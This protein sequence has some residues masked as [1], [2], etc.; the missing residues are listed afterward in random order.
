MPTINIPP[1]TGGKKGKKKPK[2]P[3]Q[4][5]AEAAATKAAKK[6]LYSP[7]DPWVTINAKGNLVPVHDPGK[8][9]HFAGQPLTRSQ[10]LS[11]FN[12]YNDL[13]LSY[14]GRPISPNEFQKFA[15]TLGWSRY[16]VIS[17]YLTKRPNFVKGPLYKQQSGDYIAAWHQVY[18]MNSTPDPNAIKNG[19]IHNMDQAT[20]MDTLMKRPDYVNSN[21]F[22][23]EQASLADAYSSIYGIPDAKGSAIIQKATLGGWTPEQLKSWLR[24]QPEYTHSEEFQSKSLAFANALMGVSGTLPVL[25]PGPNLASPYGTTQQKIPGTNAKPSSPTGSLEVQSPTTSSPIP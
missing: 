2:T 17:Q 23:T 22:K 12:Q 16:R 6:K 13:W 15:I 4:K 3:A 8:A 9:F 14:L 24:K 20:F 18:G 11:M 10:V 7:F 1:P 19:V 25:G 5:A 21:K